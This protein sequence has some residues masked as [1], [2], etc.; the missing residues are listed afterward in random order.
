MS[1]IKWSSSTILLI[2]SYFLPLSLL[3]PTP[4]RPLSRRVFSIIS[5]FLSLSL[6]LSL[7]LSLS[8]TGNRCPHISALRHI[9][10]I[11]DMCIASSP[12]LSWTFYTFITDLCNIIPLLCHS[13]YNNINHM[14]KHHQVTI[15]RSWFIIKKVILLKCIRDLDLWPYDLDLGST[16]PSHQYQ[17]YV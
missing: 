1:I 8:F 9:S 11:T 4:P 12:L 17:S 10:F 3:H 15:I 13:T 16:L 6:G 5:L 14:C 2:P 7:S